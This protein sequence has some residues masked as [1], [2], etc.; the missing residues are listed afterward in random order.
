VHGGIKAS[1]LLGSVSTYV[2]GGLGGIDGLPLK[3]NQLLINNNN[4][5]SLNTLSAYNRD[6]VPKLTSTWELRVI[7]GPF[8]NLFTSTSLNQF[9][10][11][12]WKVTHKISRFGIRLS[13]PKLKFKNQK[14]RQ[15]DVH[16]KIDPS[17]VPTLGVPLGGI[18][19][20]G[21]GEVIIIGVDGPSITGFAIIGTVI[22]ADIWKLGQLK[23]DDYI[24]FKQ[25]NLYTAIGCLKKQ[26]QLF[27]KS[28]FIKKPICF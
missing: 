9:F 3:K 5:F 14:I 2:Q 16:K 17:N 13:G 10:S 27:K 20:V 11:T 7:L 1:K 4:F 26:N 23:P 24:S 15:N 12:K 19:V 6:L 28:N 21:G 22:S 8:D 18:E 25:I